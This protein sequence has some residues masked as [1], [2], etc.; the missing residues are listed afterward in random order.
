MTFLAICTILI[1]MYAAL[2]GPKLPLTLV[3]VLG[4]AL[5]LTAIELIM[6]N[7]FIVGIMA[8]FAGLVA[9]FAVLMTYRQGSSSV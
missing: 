2:R 4:A 6:T 9:I 1:G 3:G 8:L 5:I 7:G